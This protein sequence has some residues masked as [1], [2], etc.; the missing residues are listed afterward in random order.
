MQN[1]NPSQFNNV[2]IKAPQKQLYE[3]LIHTP[4]PKTVFE[5]PQEIK[6]VSRYTVAFNL[7]SC[8]HFYPEKLV[9]LMPL[10]VG[11][12]IDIENAQNIHNEADRLESIFTILSHSV[13]DKNLID[14]TIPDAYAV[15]MKLREISYE[16]E[17]L[18]INVE[19]EG[20]THAA[21]LAGSIDIVKLDKSKITFKD[22]DY[23]R[24]R[25][26]I[27]E[28][29]NELSKIERSLFGYMKGDTPEN[30][31]KNLRESGAD[32]LNF[33]VKHMTE[34]KHGFGENTKLK[35]PNGEIIERKV[36]FSVEA[37]FPRIVVEALL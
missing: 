11:Q 33:L 1:I 21:T 17:P 23:I 28:K 27:Y 36:S 24:I 29:R 30:K 5:Q 19:D 3:E 10:N 4:E 20:I 34:S 35:L 6:D 25:D 26:K 22:Y 37:L 18:T 32:T 12:L 14:M 7:P 9:K 8:G 2:V 15:C 31:I 13:Y 16:Y